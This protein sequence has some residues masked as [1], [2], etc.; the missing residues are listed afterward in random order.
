MKH[1]VINSLNTQKIISISRKYSL[2]TLGITKAAI[3]IRG[4]GLTTL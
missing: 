2:Q 3:F 1:L 4:I